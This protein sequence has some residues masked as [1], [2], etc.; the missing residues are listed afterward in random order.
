MYFSHNHQLCYVF[1]S[2]VNIERL[3]AY[4]QPA[5]E[6]FKSLNRIQSRL[7]KAAMETDQN[8]LLCAPTVSLWGSYF[9]VTNTTYIHDHCM[10]A[11]VIVSCVFVFSFMK[12]TA[13]VY[14]TIVLD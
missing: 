4:A 13:I 12:W 6:G 3:P 5:F 10:L 9:A 8:I 11:I 7:F 14:S 1:Q 2:L